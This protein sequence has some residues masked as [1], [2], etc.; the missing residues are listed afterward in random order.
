MNE[1]NGLMVMLTTN[2]RNKECEQPIWHE[3]CLKF[4]LG[5]KPFRLNHLAAEILKNQPRPLAVFWTQQV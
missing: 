5:L 1:G 3:Q 2:N 4:V